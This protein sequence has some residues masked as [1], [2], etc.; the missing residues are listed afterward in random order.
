MAQKIFLKYQWMIFLVWQHPR[1]TFI[2]NNS[3]PHPDLL[4]LE[5]TVNVFQSSGA[6]PLPWAPG[7]L[8]R[9][10]PQCVMLC[11]S[12]LLS[13]SYSLQQSPEF[14]SCN[15][16]QWGWLPPPSLLSPSPWLSSAPVAFT[17]RCVYQIRQ[18]SQP[19]EG[20]FPIH[21]PGLTEMGNLLQWP[22]SLCLLR[23][24]ECPSSS[25]SRPGA[26]LGLGRSEA[27]L[28]SPTRRAFLVEACVL[29]LSPSLFLIDQPLGPISAFLHSQPQL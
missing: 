2:D 28:S 1:G 19:P 7:H 16:S 21:L 11:I 25:A 22:P 6:F 13:P 24:E 12:S 4:T 20:G 15:F 14:F 18:H 5:L 29:T 17:R 9:K 27:V 10:W 23:L 3:D 26:G 8:R